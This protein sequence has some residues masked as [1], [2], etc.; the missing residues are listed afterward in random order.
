MF[1]DKYEK[2][3]LPDYIEDILSLLHLN[4]YEAYGVGGSIRDSI[5]KIE[6]YDWDVTTSAL[7]EQVK[8]VFENFGVIETGIKHGTVT[9]IMKDKHVEI[10]TYRIDGEYKDGRHPDTVSFTGS[11][12][13]DLARRDFTVNAIAY[14]NEEGLID[15]FHGRADIEKKIIRTVGNP[16]KRFKE[17][18]LRILRALRFAGTLGFI[19][20]PDTVRAIRN[21]YESLL[22][23]SGERKA[24]ELKK[25]HIGNI[26]GMDWECGRNI[27][28]HKLQRNQ[29]R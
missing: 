9:V 19:I 8:K 5:L 28:G 11:L 25:L 1:G 17:D 3:N 22:K 16:E 10:T 20:H 12:R 13:Q 15:P 24:V 29:I 7:P 2:I 18:A 4:G 26:H 27:L 21:Q 6:P 14:N 23:V